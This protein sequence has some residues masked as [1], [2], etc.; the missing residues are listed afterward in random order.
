M[1]PKKQHA[2]KQIPPKKENEPLIA[3]AASSA[4][5]FHGLPTDYAGEQQQELDSLEAIYGYTGDFERVEGKA[6]AWGVSSHDR[7]TASRDLT[8]SR[9]LPI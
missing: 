9:N 4:A 6:A 3:A 8:V 2:T 5:P 1:P 7:S